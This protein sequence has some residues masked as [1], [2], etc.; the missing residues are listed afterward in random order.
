MNDPYLDKIY[1]QWN[2]ITRIY[3]EFKHKNPIIEYCVSSEKLYSYSASDY[4]DEL[5]DR[6]REQTKKQYLDAC[7]NNQFVLFIK[8]DINGKLKSYIFDIP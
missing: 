3:N 5:S 2:H 8:D 1:S 7:K 4:L 6:T